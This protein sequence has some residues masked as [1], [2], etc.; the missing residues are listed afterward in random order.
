MLPQVLL[1]PLWVQQ[2]PLKARH[3]QLMLPGTNP[4]PSAVV[5]KGRSSCTVTLLAVL[6]P[7]LR[8]VT[9]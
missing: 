2:A 7:L 5:N 4:T 6:K 9:V 3:C 8:T 1:A